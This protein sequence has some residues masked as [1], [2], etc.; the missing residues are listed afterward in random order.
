[1]T[2]NNTQLSHFISGMPTPKAEYSK[3]KLTAIFLASIPLFVAWTLLSLIA[4][5]FLKVA[6]CLGA[7]C[8][9]ANSLVNECFSLWVAAAHYCFASKF[10][11]GNG[12]PILLVHGYLHNGSDWYTIL[13]ELKKEGL[14]PVY[15]I[16]LGD[17][18]LDG[19]FWSIRDYAEQV[20]KKVAEIQEETGWDEIALVGHSMGGIVSS[21]Y[22]TKLADYGTVTDVIAIG[23]PFKGS[24]LAD[25]FAIGSCGEEMR[26]DSS[27]LEEVRQGIK[28]APEIEFYS[29]ASETD[30]VVPLSSA[31]Y[32]EDPQKQL[33]VE[34]EGHVALLTSAKVAKTVASWL[35]TK[36]L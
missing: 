4:W 7:K 34:D 33:I 10:S 19:K 14:G 27:L 30:E 20:G 3:L 28:Q 31:L 2:V 32:N 24:P 11:A 12:Q 5:P 8:A 16:D 36:N 15:T 13:D 29:I 25:C 35:K 22:A 17:G 21:L 9:W 26:P 1:M 6:S 23:S 18:T